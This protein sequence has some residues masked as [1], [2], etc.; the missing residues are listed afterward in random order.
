MQSIRT[1]LIAFIALTAATAAHAQSGMATVDATMSTFLAGGNSYTIPPACALA[2]CTNAGGIAPVAITLGA[3][4]GRVL[5]F[6]SVTGAMSFC[7]GGGCAAPTPDGLVFT[8]TSVRASGAIS[9]ISAP[10]AGFLAGVFLGNTLPL[11]PPPTLDFSAL[12]IDFASLAPTLGQQFFIGDGLTASSLVQQFL[13]PDGA[14]TLYLGIA[15]GLSFT[16]D[17]GFYDDNVGTYM[18]SYSVVT[19]V[20]EPSVVALLTVGLGLLLIGARRRRTA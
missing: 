7:P 8:N 16:D 4:S 2:N 11:V 6:G 1:T 10:R 12:T 13:V 17:P 9:G 5:T 14:T 15:D 20:P 18:A 19:T 3:G